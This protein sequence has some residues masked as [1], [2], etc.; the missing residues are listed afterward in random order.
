MST[1]LS[2]PIIGAVHNGGIT[3]RYR[4]DVDGLRAI[5]ICSVVAFHAGSTLFSGG[6]AGVDIFFAI[7][8]Y[9]IG[10]LIYRDV[11]N[12]T[13][14]YAA[15]YQRRAKRILP[16]LFTILAFCYAVVPFLLSPAETLGFSRDALAT[17]L[18]VS[19]IRFWLSSGYFSSGADL[20]PLLMTWSLGVEEQ[21]YI[22][23]PI[24]LIFLLRKF[25]T[26][27]V[28]AILLSLSVGSFV[29]SLVEVSTHPTAA[30]YMLPTRAWELGAGVLTAVYE[31]DRKNADRWIS[32]T[33]FSNALSCLGLVIVAYALVMFTKATPFPGAGAALPVFGTILVILGHTSWINRH[34]LAAKPLVFIGLLSYSW[35]LWH[36]PL[37]SLARIICDSPLSAPT[38]S[39]IVGVSFAAAVLSHRFIEQPFR[40]RHSAPSLLLR[41][42]CLASVTMLIPAFLLL[43]TH[44]WQQRFPKLARIEDDETGL[45]TDSCLISTN[46]PNLSAACVP[47]GTAQVM[48]LLG[49]SHAA[50]LAVALR[51]AIKRR[52]LALYELTKS[53]CPPIPG[54]MPMPNHPSYQSDCATYDRL[55]LDLVRHDHRIKVV[56]LAAF[57]SA[58][59]VEVGDSQNKFSHGLNAEILALQS[60]GKRVVIVKDNPR[61]AFD[62]VRRVRAQFIAPRGFLAR[63]LFGH[64]P[65]HAS[66]EALTGHPKSD[67]ASTLIDKIVTSYPNI[68]LFDLKS[69][70]CNGSTNCLYADDGNSLYVDDQHLSFLGAKRALAG[71]PLT[72]QEGIE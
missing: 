5:A 38:V 28:F 1:V 23:A 69:A 7:S 42:Y 41:R 17:I 46:S 40:L 56:V 31:S 10:G 14:S 68:I 51:T 59:L 13:F 21:F 26:S 9:L 61:F 16:A 29:I 70:L 64:D 39:A 72:Q 6:F 22:F 33:V 71:F 54:A 3:S 35:Y 36:W 53:S 37:L 2:Q 66:T 11:R 55:V 49:D 4:S 48:A 63:S 45:K 34:I 27:S 62:P 8:G 20:N 67:T 60:A 25:Q 24:L 43:F 18:S 30:F 58:P 32:T 19:N 50:S 47:G 12:G 65:I 52:N 44:G 15:F 57:W